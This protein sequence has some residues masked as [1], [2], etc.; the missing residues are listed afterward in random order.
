MI[1]FPRRNGKTKNGD[2][3]AEDVKKAREGHPVAPLKT[4]LLPIKNVPGITEVKAGSEKS[5]EHAYK[6]LRTARSDAKLVGVR[7]K[8]KKAKEDEENAKK[9]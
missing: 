4:S 7:E 8:R 9:K 3:D 6:T 5:D 1:V 2:G